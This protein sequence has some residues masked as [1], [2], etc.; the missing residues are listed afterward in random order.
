VWLDGNLRLLV[1]MTDA[2][3]NVMEIRNIHEGPIPGSTFE[4]P[5]DYKKMDMGRMMNRQKP[6]D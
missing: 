1:K 6:S 2:D 3:G 5:P 4:I